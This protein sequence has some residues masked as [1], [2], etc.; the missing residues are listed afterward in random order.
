MTEK[1]ERKIKGHWLRKKVLRVGTGI[2]LAV[3][4]LEFVVYFGS[5]LFLASWARKKVNEA[6]KEVYTI[7]FNRLNIS[8]IRRG[9]F[10]DG[11]VMKPNA[12][13]TATDD[14]TLFDFSLDQLAL[15]GSWY[16]FSDQIFYLGRMEFD[17]P[18]VTLNLA[19]RDQKEDNQAE[20]N[21]AGDGTNVAERESPVASLER[22]LRKTLEKS[23]LKALFIREIE[24]S[25]ADLF[26][27]EF[28]QRQFTKGRGQ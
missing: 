4:F 15:K 3:L 2:L 18:N 12:D 7:D 26:F 8:L 22:E 19:S 28:P 24:I 21:E 25:N 9:V 27:S 6:T 5:N 20:K 10:L 16:S 1:K 23:S 11:I 14:Q 13:L 17:N